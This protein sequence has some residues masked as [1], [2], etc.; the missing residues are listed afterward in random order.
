VL[1]CCSFWKKG[2]FLN[3]STLALHAEI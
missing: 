1:I 2:N 3:P